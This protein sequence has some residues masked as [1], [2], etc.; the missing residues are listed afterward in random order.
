METVEWN[1]FLESQLN[2]MS[3]DDRI[4]WAKTHIIT[5]L[6]RRLTFDFTTGTVIDYQETELLN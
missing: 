5:Y 1:I 2:N 4:E 6:D 3:A